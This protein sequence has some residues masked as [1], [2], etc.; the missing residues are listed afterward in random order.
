MAL[1]ST[2]LDADAAFIVQQDLPVTVTVSGTPYT[3]TRMSVRQARESASE[4][5]RNNYVFSVYLLIADFSTLPDVD[6]LVSIGGTEYLVLSK[7]TDDAVDILRLDL[8]EKFGN[9]V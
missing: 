1:D 9:G 7:D 2:I 4:G 5:L 3:G 6:D 8:G